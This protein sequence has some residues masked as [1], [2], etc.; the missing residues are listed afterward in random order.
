MNKKADK[1]AW[2]VVAITREDELVC[3]DCTTKEERKAAMF[4]AKLDDVSPIFACHITQREV[5]SR[6]GSVIQGQTT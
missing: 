5:C 6:C 4:Q 1:Q 3:F 2:D